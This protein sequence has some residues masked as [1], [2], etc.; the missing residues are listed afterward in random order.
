MAGKKSLLV[1]DFVM[2]EGA[3]VLETTL[4]LGTFTSAVIVLIT[5]PG[6]P[7]STWFPAKSNY[8]NSR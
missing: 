5:V 8:D 1:T 6:T 2:G 7:F 3:V 4:Q